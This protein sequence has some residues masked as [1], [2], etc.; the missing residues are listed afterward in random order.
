[1]AIHKDKPLVSII[2]PAYNVE[3]YIG[4]CI[5]SALNQDY[6][7]IQVIVVNDGSTDNT[8]KCISTFDKCDDRVLAIS[9]SNAGV[10]N[11]RNVGLDKATG[12][13]V[14]FLDG[15]DY[16]AKDFVSYM[17]KL[18]QETNSDF[19]ISKNCFIFENEQQPE[20]I[21]ETLSPS[22]ATSM[23]LSPVVIVGSW[24]KIYS[25]RILDD[26]NIRFNTKL[27]YGEGLEFITRVSQTVSSVGVGRRK[28]YYYRQ[29]NATS[30]TS[31][32]NINKLKNGEESLMTIRNNLK[33]NNEIVISSL[34]LHCWL[35]S[36]DGVLGIIA[37]SNKDTYKIEYCMWKK[38]LKSGLIKYSASSL[39]SNKKK[40]LAWLACIFPV[41]V[42]IWFRKKHN[43]L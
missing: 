40:V 16:L 22:N 15:D 13:Y 21:I 32:F 34:D 3:K 14:V 28:V 29:D 42:K 24:N 7:N 30:A 18:V 8:M 36:L 39:I 38:R 31:V 33:L 4:K 19:C 17:M 9:I 10:S 5:E 11:A 43:N 20:E 41:I 6:S 25:K 1:M 12:E 27:F 37:N 35:F 26:N 23:L 2:I